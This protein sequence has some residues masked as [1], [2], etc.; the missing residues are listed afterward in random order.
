MEPLLKTPTFTESISAHNE[1]LNLTARTSA[2]LTRQ[3]LVARQVSVDVVCYIQTS[4][5]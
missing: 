3:V 2:A 4:P 1:A 5:A